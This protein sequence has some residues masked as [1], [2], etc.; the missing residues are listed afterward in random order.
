MLIGYYWPR[1]KPNKSR[2]S[3]QQSETKNE[4]E[5]PQTVDEKSPLEPEPTP[6]PTLLSLLVSSFPRF[7]TI[8]KDVPFQFD[9]GTA[10]TARAVLYYE[11]TSNATFLGVYIPSSP[12]T[13][14]ACVV[15]AK[16]AREIAEHLPQAGVLITAT[17]PGENPQHVRNFTFTGLHV[18]PDPVE[19]LVG[20]DE[21]RG[22]AHRKSLR[23]VVSFSRQ[24]WCA[25][26]ESN[27]QPHGS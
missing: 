11:L 15:L 25:R 14:S 8:G 21:A 19:I 4:T 22:R 17:M 3:A 27:S 10:L 5:K 12:E 2:R 18:Q 7:F 1:I 26:R 20:E 23:T 6:E 16:Q 9:D 13:L 24:E